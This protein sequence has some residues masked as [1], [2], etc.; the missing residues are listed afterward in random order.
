MPPTMTIMRAWPDKT[1]N[2]S[3]GD[4]KPRNGANSAPARPAKPAAITNTISLKRAGSRPS[5]ANLRSFS[6]I[7]TTARPNGERTSAQQA[8]NATATVTS[9]R[10]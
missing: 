1:Q 9:T 8:S 3:S 4:A 10:K 6:R 5:A 2:I 7:A